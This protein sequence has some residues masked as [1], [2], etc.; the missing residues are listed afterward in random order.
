MSQFKPYTIK[1]GDTLYMIAQRELGDATLAMDIANLND[2]EYPFITTLGNE[3]STI[4]TFG[5]VIYLPVVVELDESSDT[6][7]N[8][9][10]FGIDLSL[11]TDNFALSLNG[12]G[13]LSTNQYGDLLTISGIRTLTQDITHSLLTEL[14]TLPLH[15]EY[16][17]T[18]LSLI[19]SKRVLG[20]EQKILIEVERVIRCDDRV[21]DVVGIELYLRGTAVFIECTIVTP[22]GEIPFKE[23]V[24]NLREVVIVEDEN[25]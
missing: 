16:G 8:Y 13:D 3:T 6:I 1:E 17:S 25:S 11:S 10:E 19:G 7:G 9:D 18:I 21:T 15:P 23:V 20:W 4:K 24:G 12:G 5:D 22:I 2:L 14:G